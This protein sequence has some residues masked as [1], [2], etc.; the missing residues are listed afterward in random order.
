MEGP[1]GAEI[2][3]K[4]R[5]ASR[6]PG[7]VARRCRLTE[8]HHW[9]PVPARAL[10]RSDHRASTSLLWLEEGLPR[11]P[12]QTSSTLPRPAEARVAD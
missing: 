9:K 3:W 5:D 12:Q 11:S 4:V 10:R 7:W 1:G 8:E 2:A 6:A